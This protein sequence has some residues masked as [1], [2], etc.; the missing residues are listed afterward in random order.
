[1]SIQPT[2]AMILAAGFGAR[3]RPLTDKMPKPLVRVAGK[4]LLDH[5]LDRLVDAGVTKAVVNVH[6]LPD[7]IVQHVA[8]REQPRVVISDER[9]VVL[10][11]GGG[12]VKAL[13]LLGGAP[14]YH[15]NADTMWIDGV[16]PNLSRLADAFD[17]SRMDILLLMAP[18]ANS[19][20]YSGC[21]DYGMNADGSLRKRKEH[22]VVPFVYAGVAIMSPAIFANAPKGEFSLTKIFDAANDQERLFGLRLDGLW[23]HVGTPEAIQAAEEALLQSAA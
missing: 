3:M 18:T 23:M 10:G 4:P 9:D 19:T 22:Q 11:T 5:V 12:V 7:Q 21:G 20:G 13:P 17:P 15:L 1:M 6:Y 16:Q 2:T 14:F 8:N